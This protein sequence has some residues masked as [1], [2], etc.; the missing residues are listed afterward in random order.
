[1]TSIQS[2]FGCFFIF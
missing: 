2:A 1:M